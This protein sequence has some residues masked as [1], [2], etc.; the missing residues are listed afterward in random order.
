[1][2]NPADQTRRGI[3]RRVE[4]TRKQLHDALTSLL[5]E[6]GYSEIALKEVLDRANVGRSTFYMHFHDKDDLLV[7]GMKSVLTS[8]RASKLPTS[9]KG[10]ER[11]IWFSLPGFEHIAE[12]NVGHQRIGKAKLGDH[13]RAVHHEYLQRVLV[14]MIGTY[15][16]EDGQMQRAEH[17]LIPPELLVRHVAST[18]ILVLNWWIERKFALGPKEI[19]ATFRALVLPSLTSF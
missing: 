18:F 4:K 16:K 3:D 11:I 5:H 17:G 9:V 6:K 1:M 15:L 14:E 2:K 10:A 19:D 13:G 7:S 8:F 12:Q